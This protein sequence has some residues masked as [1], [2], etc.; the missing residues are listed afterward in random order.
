MLGIAHTQ[1]G[2]DRHGHVCKEGGLGF[3]YSAD[4][5][6]DDARAIEW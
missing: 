2:D 4:Y 6:G 1:V 5:L 3:T